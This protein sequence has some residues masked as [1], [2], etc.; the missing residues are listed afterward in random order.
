[1]SVLA[2]PRTDTRTRV[3]IADEHPAAREGLALRLAQEPDFVVCGEAGDVP[4]VF[5]ALSPTP[6]DVLVL[7]L[8]LRGGS[9]FDLLKTLRAR[10]PAMPVLV[11]SRF[12]EAAYAERAVRAGA[13]GYIEK[14][15]PTA[16]VVAAI[17]HVLR[18]E[19][20]LSPAMTEVFLRQASGKPQGLGP[21]PLTTLSD[22]ELEVFRLIG[23]CLDT[24]A[25]AAN[26]H[27][28]A[29]TV[30]TY[31][32]RIK[33]KFGTESSAELFKLAVQWDLE[34][35]LLNESGGPGAPPGA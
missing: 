30:E 14:V 7:E 20:F 33:L 3:L 32:A 18:G 8:A 4:S 11:W 10:C 5:Q 1:M 29:K 27:L 34:N 13:G 24:N 25:I 9:G 15:Q 2:Q 12:R 21:D 28:S 22:R 16:A 19:V 35:G 17:R 26:L 31:R 23:L 6:P